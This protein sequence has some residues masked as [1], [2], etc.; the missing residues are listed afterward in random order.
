VAIFFAIGLGFVAR[1]ATT[2]RVVLNRYSGLAIQGFDPV[3][4]FTDAAPVRGLPDFEAAE[5]G[6]VWRFRNEGNRAS[7]VA[8]PNIYGPQFGGYDPVDLARGVTN[9]GN[10]RFWIIAGQRLYLFGR[11]SNRDAFAGN[12]AHF[13]KDAET[14]WPDL[15]E[16]LAQ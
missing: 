8:H 4:Y 1:A 14:R 6:A 12:P 9:A 11:E 3:A 16:T 10:P 7:F 2:E 5:A 15:E 13:L